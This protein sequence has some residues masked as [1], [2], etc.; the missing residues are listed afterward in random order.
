MVAASSLS[1]PLHSTRLHQ[2]STQLVPTWSNSIRLDPTHSDSTRL[3]LTRPDSIRLYLT[4]TTIIRLRPPEST[5]SRSNSTQLES[6]S[7]G[8]NN[9]DRRIPPNCRPLWS[10]GNDVVLLFYRNRKRR[11]C[12]PCLQCMWQRSRL[13]IQLTTLDSNP[14]VE[15]EWRRAHR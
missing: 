13:V 5:H 3:E 4:S 15:V 11:P 8:W 14:R 7:S 6:T 9:F 1:D 2:C 12:M 10:H